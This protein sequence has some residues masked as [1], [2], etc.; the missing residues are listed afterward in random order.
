LARGVLKLLKKISLILVLI[1]LVISLSGC[2]GNG[3]IEVADFNYPPSF[4]TITGRVVTMN[5]ILKNIGTKDCII[6]KVYSRE[7]WNQESPGL[8]GMYSRDLNLVLS[9]NQ[10]YKIEINPY[11]WD[12]DVIQGKEKKFNMLIELDNPDE[13]VLEE[14]SLSGLMNIKVENSPVENRDGGSAIVV[15]I[16]R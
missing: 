1:L 14:T 12:A 6:N 10:E 8:S 3:R 2:I 4:N 9:P 11:L 13:C 5:M 7:F 16:Q 15:E